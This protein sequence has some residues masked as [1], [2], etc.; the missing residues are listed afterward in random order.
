M[1]P[2]LPQGW[3]KT[4]LGQIAEPSRNRASPTEFPL[5]RYVSLG[6]VESKTMKLLGHSYT[7]NVRSSSMRFIAGDVLYGKMRPN[8]NKVWLAD[9]DGLCSAEFFVFARNDGLNNHF[10]AYRLNAD[11]FVSFADS[12]VSGE[13]PR[14]DFRKLAT[15]PILLPPL[16]EQKRIVAKLSAM[17]LT[18]ERAANSI[19]RTQHRLVTYRSTVLTAAISGKLVAGRDQSP[20]ITREL[21]AKLSKERRASWEKKEHARLRKVGREPT[22]DKWKQRYP[23]PVGLDT[24]NLPK[25]PDHWSWATLDQ[26]VQEGRPII[27]GIIKPGHHDP[28]GVPYVRVMEMKDGHIDVASLKRA[29]RAR[30]SKFTRATL[31]TG[32]ILISKDGTIG[33]VAIVPPELEGGNITQHLV[34]VSIHPLMEREYIAWAIKSDF[35]QQ[36]LIGETQGVALQGV[37]VADFRR[38]PIPIPPLAE[39]REIAAQVSRRMQSA[40]QL[41]VKLVDQLAN[42]R[43]VRQSLFRDAFSGRLVAQDANDEPAKLPEKP[44]RVK[45]QTRRQKTTAMAKS[46]PTETNKRINLLDVLRTKGRGMTPEQL[47]RESGH[48][49][50][51]VEQFFAELRELTS[52]PAKIV[53]ERT[54]SGQ[55]RLIAMP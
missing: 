54:S 1:S 35:C 21:M 22:N 28:N 36:W 26:I 33:R 8:L 51:S 52:A 10:L 48:T 20:Q 47:F 45:I 30:A 19:D 11:D 31:Q 46:K 43:R 2:K 55:I 7:D 6:H 41:S 4:T 42:A 49:Q 13:R 23:A 32:D 3:L 16:A 27:Y 39:Q 18:F 15:F 14:V 40:D 37:N 25:I 17:L 34:R 29:S 38:L 44:N 50:E 12:Q 9:F 24:K 53:E 5:S